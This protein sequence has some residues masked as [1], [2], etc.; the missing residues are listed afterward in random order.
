MIIIS[1]FH[2]MPD[3]YP[4]HYARKDCA[5]K[6]M[7]LAKINSAEKQETFSQLLQNYQ[8]ALYVCFIVQFL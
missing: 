1:D 7:R 6:D 2:V 8:T 5:K 4:W 3:T